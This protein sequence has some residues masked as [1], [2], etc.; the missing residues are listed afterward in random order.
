MRKSTFAYELRFWVSV[1]IGG[2]VAALLTVVFASAESNGVRTETANERSLISLSTKIRFT[3]MI[4]LPEGED[5]VDF[6]C[7]DADNWIINVVQNTAHIKPA[8]EGVTTNLNLVT[9]SN[10]IY[11]FLV[12]EVKT[13]ALPDLK[14][15]VQP[16]PSGI[17]ASKP[18]YASIAQVEALEAQLQQAQAAIEAA[19]RIGEKAVADVKAQVPSTLQFPYVAVPYTKPFLIRSIWHD[20]TFTYI[21]TDARERPVLYEMLDGKPAMLNFEM[22]TPDTYVVPKVM[23]GGY[24]VLGEKRLAF[25]SLGN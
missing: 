7:G 11:S 6:T 5:I 22:P 24:F 18:K 4:V 12:A 13:A 25:K 1:V 19:Q 8:K 10:R 14:V 16:D 17:K 23:D 15:Y 21:R 3:T 9:T 20:G 2:I